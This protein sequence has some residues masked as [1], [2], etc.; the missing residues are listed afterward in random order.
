M[1]KCM[2]CGKSALFTTSFGSTVLCRNCGSI[3]DVSKWNSRDFESMEDLLTQRN[4]TIQKAITGS[5]PQSIIDVIA[6]YF[7]EYIDAGFIT[8]INGKAGQL[9][10]VFADYC[11]VFTKNEGKRDEL[12]SSFSDF[13]D[14]YDDDDDDDDDDDSVFTT[15][16][17]RN[18][19]TGLMSGRLI[20]TGVGAAVTAVINKQEKEKRQE[21]RSRDRAKKEREIEKKVNTM[22]QVGEKRIDLRKIASVELYATKDVTNGY[23]KFVPRGVS[24]TN[25][26]NCEYFFFNNSKLFESKKIRRNLE[27]IK[28]TLTQ[29]IAV[30]DTEERKAKEERAKEKRKTVGQQNKADAFEEIRKYKQ[31]FDEGIIDADEFAIKKK[32]LLGL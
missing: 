14:D 1:V 29:R 31:L 19:A 13:D 32:E 9:L 11:I 16:D 7:D 23:L 28:N 3:I 22:I 20:Q 10:K 17:K 8:K 4:E 30:A 24:S 6:K 15:D 5:V 26:Y 12:V 25:L 27:T 18:L 2:A 21:Q